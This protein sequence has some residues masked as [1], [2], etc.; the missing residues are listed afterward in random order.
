M[1][2][3]FTAQPLI[4]VITAVKNSVCTI[5]RSIQSVIAQRYR[6]IEYIIID[7]ASTD[8]TVEVLKKYSCNIDHMLSEPDTGVYSA[9]NKG[10]ALATGEWVCF[11]GADDF[12][13]DISSLEV[14][15]SVMDVSL[16]LRQLNRSVM[17]HKQHRDA[18]RTFSLYTG[19]SEGTAYAFWPLIQVG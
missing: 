13:S 7:G 19:H 5:E 9:W 8:G 15:V 10:L 18:R 16:L 1:K 3:G 4:S 6:H 14:I 11:L 2:D 12:F 17:R